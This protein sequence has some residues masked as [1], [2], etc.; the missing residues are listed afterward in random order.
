MDVTGIGD[1][2]RKSG[3]GAMRSAA[4]VGYTC[5]ENGS[6]N[7]AMV[8]VSLYHHAATS[9]RTA[10]SDHVLGF[11]IAG[12]LFPDRWRAPGIALGSWRSMYK[13]FEPQPYSMKA[14]E[15][16][17][18][19]WG[20]R[21][22]GPGTNELQFVSP[23]KSNC[24]NLDGKN[25][26]KGNGRKDDGNSDQLFLSDFT[27]QSFTQD[28]ILNEGGAQ[29]AFDRY[30]QEWAKQNDESKKNIRRS[31]LDKDAHNYG[32]SFRIFATC[33]AGYSRWRPDASHGSLVANLQ[34]HCGE[35]NFGSPRRH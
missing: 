16:Y 13:R 9:R 3:G 7:G 33:P 26:D 15:D 32:V 22:T 23:G 1:A 17:Q 30:Q 25:Y 21:F 8:P 5:S 31:G 28:P 12:G 35:E 6:L 4:E 24:I 11:L 27:H 18:T 14:D 19:F 34:K 20:K 2:I 10:I 29:R